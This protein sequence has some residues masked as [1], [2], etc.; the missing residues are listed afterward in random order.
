MVCHTRRVIGVYEQFGLKGTW[1][2]Q[3]ASGQ[4]ICPALRS[5]VRAPVSCEHILMFGVCELV[6]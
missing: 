5:G 1:V 6:G 2:D 4:F 3:P